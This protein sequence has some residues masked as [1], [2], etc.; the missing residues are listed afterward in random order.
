M[1]IM[2]KSDPRFALEQLIRERGE[3]YAS[4]SRLIGRNSAYI[5]QFIKRGVPRKLDEDDRRILAQYFGVSQQMLGGPIEQTPRAVQAVAAAKTARDSELVLIPYI[6]ARASAG[7]GALG[8]DERVSGRLAFRHDWLRDL[9]GGSPTGLSVISV[10][11]DSMIPT[12]S[13]GDDILVD[14]ND[15]GDRLRDG[16]YVLRVDD[17]LNVKRL[18]MKPGGGFEVRSDNPSYPNWSD[19][20]LTTVSIIGRVVWAGRKIR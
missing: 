6:S 7:P 8:F 3:D 11:G 14:C 17:M 12:L 16:I 19:C 18:A 10:T 5:Q 2:D 15:G 9:T 20:D 1:T 13:D 4:L